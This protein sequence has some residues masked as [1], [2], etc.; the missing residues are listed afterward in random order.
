[1]KL[2][3]QIISVEPLALIISL[4]NQLLAHV[5]VT[6]IT[7]QLTQLLENMDE[8]VSMAS[9]E[10]DDED[11]GPSRKSRIP[12]LFEI[13]RP[14][15]YVC[16]IVTAVHAAGSTD[17]LGLG[18]ARDDA[19]KASRRV[20]LS[21]IP[22]K[23]NAGVVKSDLKSGLVS[24]IRMLCTDVQTDFELQTL[25][26]AV[27]SVEDHGYILDIGV[28]DVSGFLSFEEAE[29]GA[30]TAGKRLQVGHLV[31]VTVLKLSS[32]GRTCNVTSSDEFVRNSM[33]CLVLARN[34]F[35]FS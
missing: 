31:D 5:P 29:K 16:S 8:D 19:H 26:A 28:A 30:S 24:C 35:I 14:G 33:V 3:G 9:D 17:T 23:V 32:N 11:A 27:K 13:F 12:E 7:A 34:P 21:L 18:R 20:E 15:Q 1:M 25:S 10:S 4:P 22:E 2:F 6:N